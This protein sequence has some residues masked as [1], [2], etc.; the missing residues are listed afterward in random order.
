METLPQSF[1]VMYTIFFIVCLLMGI[2]YWVVQRYSAFA[3]IA[4]VMSLI[5]PLVAFIYFVQRPEDIHEYAYLKEQLKSG[6]NW[7]KFLSIG[8][9]YLMGWLLLLLKDL[10]VYLYRLPYIHNKLQPLWEKRTVLLDKLPSFKKQK[11]E[12]IIEEKKVDSN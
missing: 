2:I 9:L 7:A 5:I 10:F 12:E 4:I 8:Y 1:W 6:D 3:V 11:E